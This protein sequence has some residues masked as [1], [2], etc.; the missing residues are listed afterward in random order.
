M[1]NYR[2]TLKTDNGKFYPETE[3]S[4]VKG[5]DAGIL[6][7]VD[8][9]IILCGDSSSNFT[10][11]QAGLPPAPSTSLSYYAQNN[12]PNYMTVTNVD[13]YISFDTSNVTNMS[14]MFYNC[15]NVTSLDLRHFDTS[16]VT[17]MRQ[18]FT[19]C[20]GLTSLNF[21]GL[22]TS[23]VTDFDNAFSAVNLKTVDLTGL[24]TSRATNL[25]YMFCDCSKLE[26]IGDVTFDFTS[27]TNISQMFRNCT[28]LGQL[29]YELKFK[30]VPSSRWADK[31]A[32]RSAAYIPANC[33]VTVEN[34]I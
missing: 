3:I 26:T 4:Q 17:T 13:N 25:S 21:N 29:S 2:G 32:L 33:V 8:S 24:D 11:L 27:A 28:K 30:N 14:F 15:R 6:D 20:N 34:W 31:S 16:N 23:K 5:F 1:S 12:I 18:M 7:A 19:V 22:N 9:M 10:P